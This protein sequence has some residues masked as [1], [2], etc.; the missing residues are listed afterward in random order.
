M[1]VHV[2]EPQVVEISGALHYG[3]PHSLSR[4]GTLNPI[5]QTRKNWRQIRQHTGRK[6][7]R[8]LCVRVLGTIE[9]CCVQRFCS[10]RVD[11]IPCPL[12]LDR[13]A[14]ILLAGLL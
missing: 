1:S 8:K 14:E 12:S 13:D 4:F 11:K 7:G 2:K 10:I 6:A 9:R 5:D 3:V